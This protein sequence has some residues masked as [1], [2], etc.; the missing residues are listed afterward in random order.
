[1]S[2]FTDHGSVVSAVALTPD[3]QWLIS[4]GGD[5]MVRRRPL[6]RTGDSQLIGGHAA[7]VLSLALSTDGK[8]L[9][10]GDAE[11][12]ILVWDLSAAEPDVK[13]CRLRGYLFDAAANQSDAISYKVYDRI[14]GGTITY[15]L[16]CGSPIPPGATCV[17]NCVPGS[18]SAPSSG[19]GFWSHYWYPN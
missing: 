17:C 4:G 19:G 18:W 3:G 12:V 7:T 13:P 11:G 5:K 1:V 6:S 16:P 15:T 9:V 10:S 8:L 14:T 2:T